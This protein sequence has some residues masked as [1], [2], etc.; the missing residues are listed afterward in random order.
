MKHILLILFLF[1]NTTTY[2]ELVDSNKM[3]ETVNKQ[4]VNIN[5]QQL[6][7]ILDKDPYTVLIDVRTRDEIVEFGT[8]HR[9]QNK[10][11][12]RGLS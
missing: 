2:S 7:E 8:I 3:L 10:H 4:I 12:P 1:I 9:G 11:V 5:T 6:K